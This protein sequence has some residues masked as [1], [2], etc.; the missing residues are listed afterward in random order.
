V[1]ALPLLEFEPPTDGRPLQAAAELLRR[2]DWVAFAS[3]R[4][5]SA[6]VEAA[7]AA[8]TLEVLHTRSLAAVGPGTATALAEHGLIPSVVASV[9]TGT[10]LAEALLP[11]LQPQAT[12]LLPAAETGHR[13]LEQALLDGGVQV[14][15]VPAYRTSATG[16]PEGWAEVRARPPRC[17]L[18]G[19]PRTVQAFLALPGAAE[20]VP[21]MRAVAVGPTTAASL[22]ERGWP[23]A[24]V[25]RAPTAAGWVEAV[26]LA[27]AE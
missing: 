18:F 6:L 9:S 11:R 4:A 5:V 24:A 17:A 1:V 14:E 3:E 26:V 19:S 20:L 7:Q 2:F 12:V 15:R 21:V 16:E 27:M 25:A 22:R 13:A 10:G 23:A 8:G